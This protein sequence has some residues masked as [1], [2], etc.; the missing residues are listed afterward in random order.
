M[1]TGAISDREIK[2]ARRLADAKAVKTT[3][4]LIITFGCARAC[5]YCCN[6]Y[7]QIMSTAKPV[8]LEGLAGYS[9]ICI[10]GGEPLL[11]VERTLKIVAR[12]RTL[13]PE[14][15]IY[16]YTAWFP[17]NVKPIIDAVDGLHYT[18]HTG[19]SSIDLMGFQLLQSVI[20]KHFFD[21]EWKDKSF[22]CYISPNIRNTIPVT[23]YLW[24]RVEVKPCWLTEEEL[25][26]ERTTGA[27]SREQIFILE[28]E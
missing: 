17:G 14:A 19:A 22:R 10:T 25:L 3:A 24:K 2:R 16:L 23:P 21:P 26:A 7:K 18:L 27:L 5:P 15:K 20:C 13:Y 4:R 11:D 6:N 28:G 12:L 9:E 1:K 8:R